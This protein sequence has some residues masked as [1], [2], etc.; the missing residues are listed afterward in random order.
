MKYL[1]NLIAFIT[2]TLASLSLFHC[3]AY[4]IMGQM[5]SP[6]PLRV[7]V[8][9]QTS[10]GDM[11]FFQ[12]APALWK[13]SQ[14]MGTGID[15]ANCVCQQLA[16]NNGLANNGARYKAWL[17]DASTDAICNIVGKTGTFSSSQCGGFTSNGAPYVDVNYNPLFNSWED[18]RSGKTPD[19]TIII[20]ENR[21][22]V[23]T[24]F[25][26]I[27]TGSGDNGT[28]TNVTCNS[29]TDAGT[30]GT[31][32]GIGYLDTPTNWSVYHSTI[33]PPPTA[34]CNVYYPVYCFEQP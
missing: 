7:F 24:T 33:T 8:T 20:Q 13:V 26:S 1:R 16:M 25:Q 9:T 6:S 5:Y 11:K 18:I 29:W 34:I 22:P 23:A 3:N 4:D 15:N 10:M 12:V 31:Y 21:V 30:P 19:R 27:W 2:L 32:G 28:G 17:S 14:C